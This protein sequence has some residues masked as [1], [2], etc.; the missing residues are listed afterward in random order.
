MKCIGKA[1]LYNNTCLFSISCVVYFLLCAHIF[2]CTWVYMLHV[3]TVYT[4]D[5]KHV[6]VQANMTWNIHKMIVCLCRCSHV[7]SWCMFR[8]VEHVHVHVAQAACTNYADVNCM[9]MHVHVR[10]CVG[11]VCM[12]HVG[13]YTNT[14]C[15]HGTTCPHMFALLYTYMYMSHLRRLIFLRKSDCLGCAVLLCLVVRVTLLASFH[16]PSHLSLNMHVYTCTCMYIQ[17]KPVNLQC[18]VQSRLLV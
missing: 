14:T 11:C 9:G 13:S 6:H 4:F 1:I 2:T 10:A 16:L 5:R 15:K 17:P 7:H 12:L 8:H 18:V 3:Y